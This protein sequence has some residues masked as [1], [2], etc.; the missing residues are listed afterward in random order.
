QHQ[1]VVVLRP[2]VLAGGEIRIERT[3][4]GVIERKP[5][6]RIRI[7]GCRTGA[8]GNLERVGAG[9]AH[10]VDRSTWKENASIDISHYP[11]MRRLASEVGRGNQKLAGYLPL[12]AE[13][14]GL[15]RRLGHIEALH[16]VIRRQEREDRRILVEN[17]R[18]RIS[19]GEVRPWIREAS[20]WALNRG[21][22]AV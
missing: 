15:N 12:D 20:G 21:V 5:A 19:A 4:D 9:A 22:E 11:E 18:E 10:A 17:H 13:V 2:A 3:V 7:C 16:R 6:P 8:A 1:R 14:P